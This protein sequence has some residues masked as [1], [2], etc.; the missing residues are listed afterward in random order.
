MAYF[1]VASWHFHGQKR[2]AEEEMAHQCQ[3]MTEIIQNE[4]LLMSNTLPL[5]QITS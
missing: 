4:Y 3:S 1:D 5:F 2:W